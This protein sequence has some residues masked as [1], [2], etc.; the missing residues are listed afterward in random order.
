M[1][2]KEPLIARYRN[3]PWKF[4]T[5]LMPLQR[6]KA[7]SDYWKARIT[8]RSPTARPLRALPSL[9]ITSAH[10]AYGLHRFPH[11]SASRF[12]SA[13]STC[14]RRCSHASRPPH[15]PSISS[16]RMVDANSSPAADK[17]SFGI[18]KWFPC[19]AQGLHYQ[20]ADMCGGQKCVPKK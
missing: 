18:L 6:E 9:C 12:S 4:V 10:H 20:R 13:T 15:R 19:P 3:G 8:F 16:V 17:T 14:L 1:S 2:P 7:S 5:L 11:I